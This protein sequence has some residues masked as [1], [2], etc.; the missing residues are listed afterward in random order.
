[1]KEKSKLQKMTTLEEHRMLRAGEVSTA[2]LMRF[3]ITK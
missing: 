3:K 1:M 2:L